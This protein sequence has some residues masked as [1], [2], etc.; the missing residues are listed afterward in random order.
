MAR[1]RRML[2]EAHSFR[3]FAGVQ[4]YSPTDIYYDARMPN[5][6]VETGFT[7]GGK[8]CYLSRAWNGYVEGFTPATK[9]LREMPIVRDD[10]VVPYG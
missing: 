8:G 6:A 10:Q 7:R 4:S 9:H 3:G 1:D 5:V 2:A